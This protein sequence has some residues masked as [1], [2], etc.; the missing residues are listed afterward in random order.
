M[1]TNISHLNFKYVECF[2]N[3]VRIANFLRTTYFLRTTA[4]NGS[5]ET[6]VLEV[7][8][9]EIGLVGTH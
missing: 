1:I 5:N 3:I 7:C 8:I 6:K 2:E 9:S 4:E